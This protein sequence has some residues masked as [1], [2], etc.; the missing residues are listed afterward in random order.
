MTSRWSDLA[1]TR[2]E[3]EECLILGAYRRTEGEL[4]TLRGHRRYFHLR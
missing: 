3:H 2:L 4:P 1:E